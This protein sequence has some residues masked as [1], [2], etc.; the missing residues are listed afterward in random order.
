MNWLDILL[1]RCVRNGD[2]IRLYARDGSFITETW[3]KIDGW[4]STVVRLAEGDARVAIRRDLFQWSQRFS[5]W[6]YRYEC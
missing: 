5:C 1:H 2:R 4:F 3:A 6:V